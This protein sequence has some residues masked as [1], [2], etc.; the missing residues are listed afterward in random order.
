MMLSELYD[1]TFTV[2]NQVRFSDSIKWVKNKIRYCSKKDGI[3]D[4]SNNQM[5]YTASSW[6][7]RTKDWK[8]YKEP[9]ENGFYSLENEQMKNYFTIAPGDLIVFDDVS[10][11][12][13]NDIKSFKLL[14]DKYKD[15]GGIVSSAE[16]FIHYDRYANPW[17][18]NHIKAVRV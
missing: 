9:N 7:V 15:C 13:P 17:K 11:D 1:K 10:D 4:K 3:F 6:T 18:T 16:A 8:R 2:F 12:A 5:K 14:C